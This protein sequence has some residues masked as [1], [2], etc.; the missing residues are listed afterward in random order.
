ML[1]LLALP[2]RAED[3][4]AEA[5]PEGGVIVK[6]DNFTFSPAQITVTP[7]TTVTWINNDDIPHTVVETKKAF[8]SKTLDTEE[9]F[10][11]TFNTAGDFAY[12]CSL[13]PHMTGKVIVKPAG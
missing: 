10:S 7:G 2:A 1:V 5:A 9:K 3:K 8:R 13:H 12:F 11:F 6:I 4:P